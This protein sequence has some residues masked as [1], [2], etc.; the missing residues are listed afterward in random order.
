MPGEN[1][2]LHAYVTAGDQATIKKACDR[3]SVILI[4]PYRNHGFFQIRQIIAEATCIPD[5]Q[6]ALRQLQ[7]R[8]LAL[9]NGTFR[10]EDLL[11]LVI[12]LGLSN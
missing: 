1:E 2:P 8:E 11:G 9:L 4:L 10:P 3:V 5:G 12:R 7:L 6:N